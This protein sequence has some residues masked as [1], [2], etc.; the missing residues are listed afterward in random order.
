MPL[1]NIDVIE[2]RTGE[3]IQTL[4]DTI[5]NAMVEAFDVP[6][7]DRYQV[8]TQHQPHEITALDTGLGLTRTRN[9][10]I[11]RFTSR[12][13]PRTA[14]ENL[15]RLLAEG[16]QK[17]CGINPDDLIVTITENDAA[18]WSFGRGTGTIPLTVYPAVPINS[19]QRSGSG[20]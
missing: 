2:G 1:I 3:E 7:E 18:D 17:N 10:V 13:R 12:S 11:L 6:T 16:L 20:R 4:L 15:Y 8:L 9:L 14:K 19:S 5:H